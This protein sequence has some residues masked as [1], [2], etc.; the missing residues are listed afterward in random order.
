MTTTS[1]RLRW[2]LAVALVMLTMTLHASPVFA[3]AGSGGSRGSRSYSTPARPPAA[4]TTPSSPSR[5][6]TAPSSP[7]PA[8]RG[9]FGPVMGGLAGFALG[10][11][12]GGM[13]FGHGFGGG[14]GLMDLL[15]IGGALYLLYRVMS[16]R[17]AQQPAYAG[18][19][20]YDGRATSGA[21]VAYP[22]GTAVAEPASELETG[23]AHIR[24]MDPSFDPGV[25]AD[26]AR[27]LFPE[28]QRAVAARDM[29]AVSARLTPRMYT[30]LV[31]QCDRLR[32]A[33]RTNR[34]EQIDVRR[35]EVSEAW[36]ESGQD[37]ATVYLSGSLV[38][39]TVE[40]G[41]GALIEGTRTP[42]EFTEYWTFARP[43]GPNSWKLSAIQTE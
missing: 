7:A 19:G 6:Y 29:S 3:R 17:R 13:L 25:V 10:G 26:Q 30:T 20:G 24:Q 9:W 32:G 42:Q 4:P 35:A 11:L 23:F 40:D 28:V 12:L 1:T 15:L 43:V 37:Y 36:Q 18:A 2:A 34:L 33:A 38:D 31:G 41:S 39:Y 8:S 5:Q 22:A 27:R 21:D 16:A 14:F